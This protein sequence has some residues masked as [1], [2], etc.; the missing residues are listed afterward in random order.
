MKQDSQ[1]GSNGTSRSGEAPRPL[2]EQR[3]LEATDGWRPKQRQAALTMALGD[4]EMAFGPGTRP[5][6]PGLVGVVER[7]RLIAAALAL[8]AETGW[9]KVR[10]DDIAERAGLERNIIYR[11]YSNKGA[12]FLEALQAAEEYLGDRVEEAVAA[13]K[14]WRDRLELALEAVARFVVAEPGAA[15][16][17]LVE[18]RSAGPRPVHL[19]DTMLEH[20]AECLRALIEN[21]RVNA[22]AA[23]TPDGIVGGVAS[24]FYTRLAKGEVE[25]LEEVV[26]S[27]QYFALVSYIGHEEATAKSGE[28]ADG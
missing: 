26:P 1:Q 12:L 3:I 15:K 18:A 5:L 20:Y 2:T 10:L 17:L 28:P 24:F 19:F 22:H 16:A 13:G 21:E 9:R 4:G 27:L 25:D 8:A 14:G 6:S 7:E 23:L 11:H